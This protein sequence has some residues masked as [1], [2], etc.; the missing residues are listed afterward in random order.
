MRS[1]H[2]T[3]MCMQASLLRALDDDMAVHLL[4]PL[5]LAPG[6]PS[7]YLPHPSS[8]AADEPPPAAGTGAHAPTDLHAGSA[9]EPVQLRNQ[10]PAPGAAA[11]QGDANGA[12]AE[13]DAGGGSR[14]DQAPNPALVELAR[15]AACG[16]LQRAAVMCSMV[17]DL[18]LARLTPLL[19]PGAGTLWASVLIAGATCLCLVTLLHACGDSNLPVPTTCP[20][21]QILL[22]V[23]VHF[24]VALRPGLGLLMTVTAFSRDGWHGCAR[25]TP[26]AAGP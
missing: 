4:P 6:G 7:A 3:R 22:A 2:E 18:A 25:C 5:Q 10:V 12:G 20:S 17:A 16:R 24:A 11:R 26:H 15:L 23:W 9:A 8:G 13:R 19:D 14:V 1:G 21:I